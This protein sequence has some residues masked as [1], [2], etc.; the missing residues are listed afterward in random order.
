MRRRPIGRR[1]RTAE[2]CRSSAARSRPRRR[3]L[4]SPLGDPRWTRRRPT[5]EAGIGKTR[6]AEACVDAVRRDG[7][8]VLAARAYADGAGDRLRPDR[9]A[10]PLGAGRCRTADRLACPRSGRARRSSI[11]CCRPSIGV[12][13][14]TGRCRR[15]GR[16]GAPGRG[17]R[18][19]DRGRSS[20]ARPPGLLWVDDV[21]WVDAALAEALAYLARRL[22]GRPLLLLL[23]WRPE[24]LDEPGLAFARQVDARSRRRRSSSLERLDRADVGALVAR[25]DRR[26][27]SPPPA[28][29]DALV[30]GSRRACRSTSS[31][32]SRGEPSRAAAMPRRRPG[33]PPRAARRGRRDGRAGPRRR[34]RIGRS[35]DLATVRYASGR[36]EDETVEALEELVRRGLV[37]EVPGRP[38]RIAR[39]AYDFAHARAARPRRTRRRAWPAAACSIGGSPRRCGWTSAARPRRPRPARPDRRARARGRPRRR[40]G[41]GVPGGGRP[42]RGAVRE[43]RGDRPLLGGARARPSGRRRRCTPRSASCGRGSATTPARSPRSRPRPRWPTPSDLPGLELALARAHI[44][45]GDLDGRRPPSRRRPARRADDDAPAGADAGGSL[46]RPATGR[47]LGRRRRRRGRGPGRG[48]ARR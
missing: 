28:E 48:D 4:G 34:G 41:R 43:P 2:S 37:R 1:R 16:P 21:Q 47:R 12:G 25:R 27:T 20:R 46:D 40:G 35:F 15:P 39:S 22:A 29:V 32:R 36:S 10:P 18:R 3:R 19:R 7:G 33:P 30:A 31:R 26:R 13:R 24:D 14:A 8:V 17:D 23:T 38:A 11:G 5:G 42:G 6:L 9:R 44:R 45:R